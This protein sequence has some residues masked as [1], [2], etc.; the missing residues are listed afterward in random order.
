MKLDRLDRLAEMLR[1]IMLTVC[2]VSFGAM[3]LSVAAMVVWITW[4]L[5]TGH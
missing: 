3:A 2:A 1:D 5:I 4:N